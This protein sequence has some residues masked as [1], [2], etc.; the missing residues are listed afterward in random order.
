MKLG[1]ISTMEGSPWGGSEELWVGAARHLLQGG[2]SV[3]ACI[4]DWNTAEAAPFR[5]LAAAG[6][7]IHRRRQ[8]APQSTVSL[9]AERLRHRL[10]LSRPEPSAIE[11]FAAQRPDLTLVSVAGGFPTSHYCAPLLRG[12]L[13]FAILFQAASESWW[14]DDGIREDAVSVLEQ[15]VGVFYVSA[16]NRRLVERQLV[17]THPR[18]RTVANPFK[19]DFDCPL[20][21]PDENTLRIAVVGRLEPAAKGCDLALEA[22]ASLAWR[23]R[24]ATV[25]FF[26]T[27]SAARGVQ[28]LAAKLGANARFS[29][30]VDDVTRLWREHHL[31]LL[32]S[33]FEGLPLAIIEAQLC[34]RPCVTTDVGGN[35]ELVREGVNGFLAPSP[36]LEAVASALERAWAHRGRWRE[37]GAAAAESIRVVVPRD[38]TR[39]FAELLLEAGS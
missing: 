18:S 5:V 33:R 31:L 30:H 20:P 29:G 23:S 27:G 32:P 17:F 4:R 2:H 1:F 10:L 28:A 16:G 26:G 14:P 35:G 34:G 37:M 3:D 9:V 12:R 7:R 22:L 25:T 24:P 19:A 8:P 38:P 15:A 11:Q 21:W 36:T 6:A 13:R 39:T